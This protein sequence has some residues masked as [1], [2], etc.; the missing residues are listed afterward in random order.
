MNGAAVIADIVPTQ[1]GYNP[2]PFA[3]PISLLA[4]NISL[5][6]SSIF[7][8]LP[9][10]RLLARLRKGTFGSLSEASEIPATS[11][12]EDWASTYAPVQSTETPLPSAIDQLSM[13]PGPWGFF[14][15]WYMLGLLI[16]AL[17]LHRMQ[18]VIIPSRIPA[19][20]SRHAYRFGPTFA[21]PIQRNN[22]IWRQLYAAVLPLNFGRTTTRLV[23][24]LP[25]IYF[26]SKM[27]LIWLLLV[28]QTSEILPKLTD[29]D[30]QKTT[31]WGVLGS[32]DSLGKWCVQK[33]MS[34]ICWGTFCAVCGA[35]LVEGLIKALDGMGSGFPIAN[36]NPNT[37]PF[38]L[39]QVGYAFLLHVYSSPI[40]HVFKP[41]D[42]SPSR[43]DKH[44]IITITI[45]LLQLTIFHILSI[46][47]RL[48]GHRLLPTALTSI[49]SLAHFHGTLYSK[50]FFQSSSPSPSLTAAASITPTSTTAQRLS[51]YLGRQSGVNYPLL[52][53]IPNIFETLLICTILLTVFINAFV[54][55]LVRGRV[56]RVLSGL[57]VGQGTALH[58]EDEPEPG[59]FQTLPFEEDFGVL[60]L[61]VGIASMEA[62]GL[63][64][65]G[66]EVAPINLPTRKSGSSRGKGDSAFGVVRMGR[67]GVGNV[68]YGLPSA[69]FASSISPDFA[70]MME[71]RQRKKTPAPITNRGFSNEVRTVDLGVS[72]AAE[73]AHG[74]WWKWMK[75]IAA[76]L[77]AIWDVLKGLVIFLIER[78][79]GTVR[80]REAARK[81]RRVDRRQETPGLDD[82]LTAHIEEDEV[83]EEEIQSRNERETYQRFLKG[84]D[85]SD[86]EDDEVG[87]VFSEDEEESEE[88]GE[89]G[90]EEAEAVGLFT[91]LLRNS[92]G[93]VGSTS[94]A[95]PPST[96]PGH[97]SGEMVLAH[98]MHGGNGASPLTR[99]RWNALVKNDPDP[100]SDS[101]YR[102]ASP[103]D[104][105]GLGEYDILA[106]SAARP[107]FGGYTPEDEARGVQSACVICTMEVRDI[108]CWP[109]RCLAMCDSC[110]EALASKSTPSKHRC[111][112]C[113]QIVEGYSRIYI[114]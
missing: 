34:E 63:R 8:R 41:T 45:P 90:G 38:N 109:C 84:Q 73:Y 21:T 58:D 80:V 81:P 97:G 93:R 86:D 32:F 47:K 56:D 108:I 103:D 88:E 12:V 14:T 91:D 104:F 94:S 5:N 52:N 27:L 89:E 66:N 64:G 100:G 95:L 83:S 3:T 15:S 11:V 30:V 36:A 112:C 53:Y 43:P 40:A 28:L 37:S 51:P 23:L 54:Q 72:E 96:S 74:R 57:G 79:K 26:L 59:F 31:W 33:E 62:T 82:N 39:N 68:H 29:A 24:H 67:V 35:F 55:L 6:F 69:P 1:Q 65:W 110:R 18:N 46:S 49:L 19:R 50:L 70:Q 13:F 92:G 16:M 2:P 7:A 20:R 85:I 75:E 111:P 87:S 105:C 114:P 107:M 102:H 9:T 71:T 101:L 10:S 76:F 98:L 77:S 106:E 78:A 99:R 25:S 60:L 42:G 4:Y 113:R 48:S 22:V 17:L 61:R 44:V